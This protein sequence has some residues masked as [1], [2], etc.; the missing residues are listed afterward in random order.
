MLNQSELTSEDARVSSFS[1]VLKLWSMVGDEEY[2]SV[3]VDAKIL[4]LT[5]NVFRSGVHFQDIVPVSPCKRIMVVSVTERASSPGEGGGG[6]RFTHPCP[7]K[8]RYG[9][10]SDIGVVVVFLQKGVG[11]FFSMA[12]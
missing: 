3:V 4:K 5:H 2:N 7:K 1:A 6:G 9:A 8:C 11:F 10:F 12:L